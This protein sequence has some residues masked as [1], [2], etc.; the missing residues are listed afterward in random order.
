V[1]PN[2]PAA[3]ATWLA[4]TQT[5]KP[6]A[7]MPQVALDAADRQAVVHYLGGLQ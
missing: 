1:L 2:T 6:G 5:V 3:R 4:D 7:L